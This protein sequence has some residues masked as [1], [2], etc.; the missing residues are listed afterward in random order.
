MNINSE[1]LYQ[2][3]EDSRV[4]LLL[5]SYNE[6]PQDP[7]TRITHHD[8]WIALVHADLEHGVEYNRRVFNAEHRVHK[9]FAEK[10]RIDGD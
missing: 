2:T 1:A 7:A 4:A 9:H 8:S 3:F 10:Y 6:L 5:E